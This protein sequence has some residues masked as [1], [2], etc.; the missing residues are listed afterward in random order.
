MELGASY[1]IEAL[2]YYGSPAAQVCFDS[3]LKLILMLGLVSHLPL[4]RQYTT[5]YLWALG[6][7]IWLVSQA[8]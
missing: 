1:K 8:Q 4:D 2:G 3:G 5:D 6:L 7:A